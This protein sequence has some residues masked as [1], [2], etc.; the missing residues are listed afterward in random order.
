MCVCSDKSFWTVRVELVRMIPEN[1]VFVAVESKLSTPLHELLFFYL[2][3][4]SG[5]RNYILKVFSCLLES[6]VVIIFIEPS[7]YHRFGLG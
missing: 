7:K 4:N 6:I 2:T 1:A 5:V 3:I